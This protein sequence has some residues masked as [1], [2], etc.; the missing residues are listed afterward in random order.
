MLGPAPP[1]S[2]GPAIA[3]MRDPRVA[4]KASSYSSLVPAGSPSAPLKVI[5]TC[6]M[7]PLGLTTAGVGSFSLSGLEGQLLDYN[8]FKA[9]SS[10]RSFSSRIAYLSQCNYFLILF[11][12]FL[13]ATRSIARPFFS[14]YA[15]YPV[16]L[17]DSFGL[18]RP[19]LPLAWRYKV[20]ELGSSTGSYL[21]L[22][23]YSGFSSARSGSS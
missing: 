5:P 3:F 1:L 2:P 19:M 12:S 7:N 6:S 9:S 16:G 22:A 15:F 23:A 18:S 21:A 11:C 14:G 13:S 4:S 8:S 20:V 17:P 10:Y